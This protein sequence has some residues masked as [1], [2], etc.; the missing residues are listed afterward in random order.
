MTKRSTR[1]QSILVVDDEA[2]VRRSV[3]GF[4]EDEDYAATGVANGNEALGVL[5]T[6]HVDLVVLDVWMEGMSGLD[7]L[8]VIRERWPDLPVLMM[9]GHGSIDLAVRATRRGAY[10]FLEK[11]LS[12]E[13][14]AITVA[15]ALEHTTQVRA[16]A[17]LRSELRAGFTL[18]G[19]SPPME[20]LLADVTRVAGSDGR[21][22]IVGEN[23]TGKELVA[24]AIH[25]NSPRAQGPFVRLNSAA[26][27]KDLVESELFGYEK[28]AFTGATTRKQGKLEVADQ[29]TLFLDEIGDMDASA[30]AKLLRA[31]E[32]GEVERL[33]GTHAIRFDVRVI[34]ATNKDLKAEIRDNRFRQDL[35]FRL[36]VVPLVVPP[37]RERGEDIL[38]LSTH[39]L[40]HYCQ[41]QGRPP[42]RFTSEAEALLR[43][44]SWP[45]NVRELRNLMERLSIMT[46]EVTIDAGDLSPL[47]DPVSDTGGGR[48]TLATGSLRDRLEEEER[49]ILWG[50]LDR[51]GWNVS[52]C[53]RQLEIDRASLHRKIKKYDLAKDANEA[54]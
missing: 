49:R 16:Q 6:D 4:L 26:I 19:T 52:E 45:G 42:K 9:S 27:P 31:L 15:R 43:R 44:Y 46:D 50:E 13:R 30:Q 18:L 54:R 22:L 14:L 20:K 12:P 5:D 11:P 40:T 53:A 25:D 29:G 36:A 2:S 37:L 34:S 3:V 51:C 32:T 28:G 21:V 17:V 24:R 39:F 7:L 8:D 35:Y 38:L 41:E 47:L 48:P 23:G 33:G 10:D 1:S